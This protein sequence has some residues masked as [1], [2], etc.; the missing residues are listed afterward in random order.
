[1]PSV[2]EFIRQVDGRRFGSGVALLVILA[3]YS[4]LSKLILSPTYGSLPAEIFHA[5]GVAIFGGAGW[6]LKDIIPKRLGRAGGYLLPVLAF[7][8]PTLQYFMKQKSSS[9]GNPLG[10]VITE[11]CGYYPLVLLTVAYAGKLIQTA[12]RLESQGDLVVEHVPLLGTYIFYSIGDHFANM[13]LHWIVGTTFLFTRVGMQMIL[14]VCYSA[15]LPSKLLVLAIPSVIFSFTSNVHFAGISGVN[16]AIEHEGYSL[17]ARHESTTGYISVLDNHNDGF[18]VMRC[19]HSLLGGQWT[20]LPSGY[21]P[22]VEDPIYAIFAMLEAVRL[23]EP[24]HGVSR[25]DADSKALVIGLGIGT[26]PA[27]LIKHGIETT[28]VEIDPTVHKYA[29]Q[30]FNLPPNH[31]PVIQDAV[32]YV[33]KA[34]S[35]S[36]PIQYDYIVHDVFTGGAEPAELFTYEFLKGLEALLK[37][38]GVIAI[39]YAGDL[40]LY[41]TGLVVRTI[42]AVFP[43]CRIFREQ[44]PVGSDENTDFTNMVLFCK[45]S[46]GT[47]LRFRDPVQADFLRS[48]S[49][50][51]YLV[52]KHELDPAIFASYPKNGRALL[53]EKEVGR[54][55]KYQDRSA[56]AHWGIMRKVLPDAV[57]E[58][59]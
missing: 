46:A 39:N 4:P 33:K 23:V 17:V 22:E 30:Y 47:P 20:K 38:D 24:D 9:L 41:P 1:M 28:I 19:D 40:T 49:R 13:I 52:P 50:E 25:V 7:W 59:W 48:K 26:T 45:K 10:P 11:L 14:A 51:S 55:H 58:N 43:S 15:I 16:S 21:R 37:D 18:R 31:I 32:K 56:L 8:V 35:S 44:A 42:Q 29:I 12:L 27:A 2:E 53:W 57:W 6:F 34:Q 36:K 3:F 5:Y 54:L